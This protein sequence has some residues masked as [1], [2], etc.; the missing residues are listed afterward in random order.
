LLRLI[1]TEVR[2]PLT[3]EILFGRLE[4]GGTVT[5]ALE[6]DALAF[7]VVPSTTRPEIAP[8]PAPER[9]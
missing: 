1:Q 7:R 2:D 8:P 3:E 4:H 9:V 6:G 5:I